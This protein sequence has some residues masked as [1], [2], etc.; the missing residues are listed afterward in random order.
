MD[1]QKLSIIFASFL[2]LVFCYTTWESIGFA[3]RARFFPLYISVAAAIITLLH[4]IISVVK[5]RKGHKE[6]FES[7]QE[8]SEDDESVIKYIVWVIG[9]IAVIY[10]IGFLPATV[11]FLA[12]FLLVV[13][14]FSI[15][16]TVISMVVTLGLILT[17][18]SV[19]NLYWHEGLINI[20]SLFMG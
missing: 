9:Y 5:L 18:G 8:A 16:K 3:D 6:Q 4:I 13:T 20:Q 2:F 11:I 12:A 14:K 7:D 19:M 1:K 17:F 15:I 10:L